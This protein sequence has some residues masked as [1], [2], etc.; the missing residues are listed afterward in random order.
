MGWGRLG[1]WNKGKNKNRSILPLT[2]VKQKARMT[3]S[4]QFRKSSVK[5]CNSENVGL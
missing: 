3:Y 4:T 2:D 5:A 1:E